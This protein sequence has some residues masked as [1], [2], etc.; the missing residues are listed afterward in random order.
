MARAPP[1]AGRRAGAQPPQSQGEGA[2]EGALERVL[3]RHEHSRGTLILDGLAIAAADTD[4]EITPRPSTARRLATVERTTSVELEGR[5]DQLSS[6]VE[7]VRADVDIALEGLRQ[8]RAQHDAELAA[9]RACFEAEARAAIAPASLPAGPPDPLGEGLD[10]AQVQRV[11]LLLESAAHS[12]HQRQA[13]TRHVPLSASEGTSESLVAAKL[14]VLCATPPGFDPSDTDLALQ[15]RLE[16]EL[17]VKYGI[18]CDDVAGATAGDTSAS[19]REAAA[20][21]VSLGRYAAGLDSVL[22]E[23]DR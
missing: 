9:T 19:S 10:R 18:T 22:D 2:Q 7:G 6:A 12:E 5:A 13:A 3:L 11:Q 15:R 14:D 17:M 4:A 23:L 21:K 20:L 8:W 16:R 1:L